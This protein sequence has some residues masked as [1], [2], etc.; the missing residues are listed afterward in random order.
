MANLIFENKHFVLT[1]G[2]DAIAKSLVLKANGE[3]CLVEGENMALFSITEDRPYNNEIKLAHPNKKTTFEA[4]RIRR[5]GN[6]LIVGFELICFEAVVEVT[7]AEDYIGFRIKEFLADAKLFEKDIN[8]LPVAEFRLLQLPVKKRERFGEWLGVMWDDKAAVNLLATNPFPRVDSQKRKD[9]RVMYADALREVKLLQCG[10]ALVATQPEKLLDC[11]DSVEKDYD[12]PRGVESRRAR[13]TI[14]ASIYWA[15]DI[16]PD[17]VDEHIYWAKKGGFRLMLFYYACMVTKGCSY[18]TCGDYEYKDTYPNGAED[19]K[20][21]LD[22]MRAAGI[23]PGFHFLQTHIGI[24]SHYVTP[25][26][27][28]RLNLVRRFTLSR[29]ISAEDDVIYVD[30]NPEGAAMNENGRVLRFGKEAIHYETYSAE[31]PYC[32]RGCKRGHYNTIPEAHEEGTGGGVLDVSEFGRGVSIYAD[33][34][35]DL[36]DE[37]AEELATVYNLGFEFIY[38]DGSEGVN[39]PFEIYVPYAQYRVYQKLKKAPLFCEGAAKAHFGWHMLSGGNAFDIFPKP[40]FK[41]KIAQFPLEE[42]PRMA[43]DFTRVN[44]GWWLLDNATMPD[45]FEYGTSKAASWDSPTTLQTSIEAYRNN[46]PRLEDVYEVMARWEDVRA[47]NWL[48]EEQKLALRDPD[49][50]FILLVNE[51]G[52]YELVPYFEIKNVAGE[53]FP[54][55]AFYFVRNGKNYVVCWHKTGEGVLELAL[56][57]ENAVFEVQLGGERVAIAPTE[58]GCRIPVAGRRYF[59]TELPLE[60]LVKA[61]ETAGMV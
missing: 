58:R 9:C 10:V 26:V 6:K 28:R 3:E 57:D 55:S 61:F 46:P 17:T 34:R 29:S 51:E 44:F 53:E 15:H 48:T 24:D 60:Q 39:P 47:K 40:I 35:T 54:V 22:K 59:Q 27:D 56:K 32:F 41:E 13:E 25:R 52:A 8:P 23:T 31:Y 7:E 16:N 5:E 43:N 18:R 14:N 2:D 20:M 50:E 21:V 45:M 30:Q 4:N 42:A 49:Q 1:V 19:M 38:F 12:L 33:Q 11:I 37:I 36:P